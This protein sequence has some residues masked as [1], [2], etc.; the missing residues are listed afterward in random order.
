MEKLCPLCGE[1]LTLRIN[2]YDD[3]EFYGCSAFP[4]CEYTEKILE[5]AEE[6]WD[7]DKTY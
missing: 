6:G 7:V 1:K 5:E 2:K 3:S 4:D